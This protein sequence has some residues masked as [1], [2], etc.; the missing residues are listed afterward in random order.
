MSAPMIAIYEPLYLPGQQLAED[1]FRPLRLENNDF[2]DWREFRILV[3]MYRRGLHREQQFT[4][5][6]SPKFGLKTGLSGRDFLAFVEANADADVCFVNPFP[7]LAYISHN[8][9]MQGEHAHPGLTVRSQALLDAVGIDIVLDDVPR[10]GPDVLCYSNYWVGKERFWD[11]YV[12]GLLLPIAQFLETHPDHP[13][14]RAIMEPTIHLEAAPFLPFMI[15]RLFST[16]L[17]LN[18]ASVSFRAFPA[19]PIALC[20]TDLERDLVSRQRDAVDAADRAELFPAAMKNEMLK[21]SALRQSY[22]HDYFDIH[23]HPHA[24]GPAGQVAIPQ[25]PTKA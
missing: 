17:S 4:G 7:Q 13:A 3:D 8:V 23:A 25:K 6:L 22:D 5:L 16:Y 12:G 2:A 10:H 15:E 1:A 20:L 14:S 9:W 21:L 11:E 24:K 18:R 19:D